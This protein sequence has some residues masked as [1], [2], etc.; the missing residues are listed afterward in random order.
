MIPEPSSQ[1][2]YSGTGY[3]GAGTG[4]FNRQ[5]SK[6]PPDEVFCAGTSNEHRISVKMTAGQHR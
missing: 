1:I 6:S 2:P 3:S 4:Y 5:K